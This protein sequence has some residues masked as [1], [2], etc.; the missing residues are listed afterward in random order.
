LSGLNLWANHMP[1]CATDREK[2]FC[3]TIDRPFE[4]YVQAIAPPVGLQRDAG[5]AFR[6]LPN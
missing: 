3:V 4:I 6:V 5:S 2:S 1:L